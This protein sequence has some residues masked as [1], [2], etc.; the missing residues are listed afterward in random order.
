M[1]LD[2][3]ILSLSYRDNLPEYAMNLHCSIRKQI[4]RQF[5]SYCVCQSC[6]E[7]MRKMSAI[8][9]QYCMIVFEIIDTEATVKKSRNQPVLLMCLI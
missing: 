5:D 7:L 9:V 2:A 3:C 4:P 6:H 8:D 1:L